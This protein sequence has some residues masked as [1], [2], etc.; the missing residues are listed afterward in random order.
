MLQH[1]LTSAAKNFYDCAEADY[2]LFQRRLDFTNLLRPKYIPSVV[3]ALRVCIKFITIA[4][5]HKVSRS[6]TIFNF[7]MSFKRIGCLL[8]EKTLSV[9]AKRSH[10]ILDFILSSRLQQICQNFIHLISHTEMNRSIRHVDWP[11]KCFHK[12]MC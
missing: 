12:G 7:F 4:T 3:S 11:R 1:F 6:W 2:Q 5:I 10:C 9:R 8:T